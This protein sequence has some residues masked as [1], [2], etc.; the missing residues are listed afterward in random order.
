[1]VTIDH[2]SQKSV[3]QR[4]GKIYMVEYC[5]IFEMVFAKILDFWRWLK[6]LYEAPKPNFLSP[7]FQFR[8]HPIHGPII[9][10]IRISGG[11]GR[12]I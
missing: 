6:T 2:I 11:R 12:K 1:M 9:W 4:V 3:F 5:E 8:R 7:D 10:V